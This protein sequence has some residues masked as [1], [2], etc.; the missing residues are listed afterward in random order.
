MSQPEL[1]AAITRVLEAADVPYMLTGSWASSVYGEPRSTHD[2]DLVI[3]VWLD[4][5][6]ALR[7]AFDSSDYAF[8]DVAAANAVRTRGM[9]QLWHHASGAS[10]DFWVCADE[11]FAVASLERRRRLDVLGVPLYVIAPED[12]VVQKLR[13]AD[14]SG[15]S[16]KQ[17]NDVRGVLDVQAGSLDVG[18]I[19]RWANELGID[20]LWH[21]VRDRARP[22]Q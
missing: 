17:M 4:A 7:A 10:V 19:D 5:V 13:W 8:D 1:L 14:M 9:F 16:E 18:H 12:L 2:V 6:Q 21:S 15:G 3:D 22:D 20:A 11:P